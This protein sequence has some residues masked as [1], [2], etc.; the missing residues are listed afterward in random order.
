MVFEENANLNTCMIILR[1]ARL[2]S[3]I[4]MY[5]VWTS[6]WYEGMKQQ[7]ETKLSMQKVGEKEENQ[8]K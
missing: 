3:G 5:N 2:K 6:K 7:K 1:A 8:R 4:K